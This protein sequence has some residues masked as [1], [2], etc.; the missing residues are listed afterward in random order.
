M[1]Q[2][3]YKV[4]GLDCASCAA[5]IEDQGRKLDFIED[6]SIDLMGNSVR[7]NLSDVADEKL[8]FESLN[9]LAD[10]IEPGAKFYDEHTH[11]EH[12]HHHEHHA[13]QSDL[14]RVIIS[15]LI[16]VFSYFIKNDSL[17]FILYISAYLIVGYDVIILAIKNLIRGQ[18]LDEHFLMS[19]ATLGAFL[20]NER[21]EAVLVMLLYQLGEYLQGLAVD[22]SKKSISNL[23]DIKPDFA[24]KIVNG[25]EVRVNPDEVLVDDIIVVRAGEKIPLDGVV[26]DGV[27]SIDTKALTG[28]SLPREVVLDSEVLSG[29]INIDGLIKVRVTKA[30]FESTVKQILDLVEN[31]SANKA[32]SEKFIARFA[33]IYTPVVVL[34]A[35]ILAFIVPLVTIGKIYEYNYLYNALTFLVISCPCALVI[36]V[37]L[38]FFGGIGGA[39]KAGIL[40]KG[41]NY[42]EMLSKVDTVLFD[43]TGTLTK[44]NFK[45]SEVISE[46]DKKEVIK[47]AAIAEYYSLH[48]IAKSIVSEYNQNIDEK[49]IKDVVE[50]AHHGVG[51]VYEDKQIWAGNYKLMKLKNIEAKEVSTNKSIVYVAVNNEYLGSIIVE[52]EIKEESF[53]AV[54]SLRKLLVDN[55]VMVTGDSDVIANEVSSN[56]N[57][58]DV[59]S[60]LTPIDKVNVV[61]KYI[62]ADKTVAFVGDGIND[63]PVL[64]EANVG[65]AMGALGSDAAIEAA[66]VVIMDDNPYKLAVAINHSRKTMK[67]V[68]QNITFAL[69]IKF[70]FLILGTIGI[71]NMAMAVF[72]DVGVSLLAILNSIR[73]LKVKVEI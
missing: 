40:F 70:L 22:Q 1:K 20:I 26:V 58:D 13:N 47:Y 12:D 16:L 73:L 5:S 64:I 34:F 38:S 32:E 62:K 53:K 57:L 59:Y 69:T 23:M 66:D 7:V 56:L 19:I 43:K 3:N 25:S 10:K 52:D 33:K 42:I 28:E 36:S 17:N 30:Y 46:F 9:K 68:K 54:S 50:I 8:V 35:F 67:I 44:G 15:T 72:A 2:V 48:P 18:A 4:G 51:V 71:S 31:A 55:L 61:D 45:V 6:I 41:S 29:S 24:N 39:S 65:V 63:A 11:D 37:P 49:K 21:F 14:M 60:S 27:S